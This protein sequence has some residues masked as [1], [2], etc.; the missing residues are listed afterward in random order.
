MKCVFWK[1]QQGRERCRDRLHRRLGDASRVSW[2]ALVSEGSK[3][4]EWGIE[5]TSQ[6]EESGP[7]GPGQILKVRGVKGEILLTCRS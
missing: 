6:G 3:M 7:R 4:G 5:Q 2:D 1:E